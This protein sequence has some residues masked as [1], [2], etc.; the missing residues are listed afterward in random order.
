MLLAAGCT[1]T[2]DGRLLMGRHLV[3]EARRSVPNVVNVYD[4][5]G[6]LAMELGGYNSYFG[7]APTS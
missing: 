7:T 1:R 4:R 5:V 2:H 6:E 3:E